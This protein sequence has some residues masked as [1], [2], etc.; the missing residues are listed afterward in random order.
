MHHTAPMAQQRCMLPRSCTTACLGT[1]SSCMCPPRQALP[2]LPLPCGLTVDCT[3]GQ[4]ATNAN[5]RSHYTSAH[6]PAATH[7]NVVPQPHDKGSQI[8]LLPDGMRQRQASQPGKFTAQHTQAIE[9][10]QLCSPALGPFSQLPCGKSASVLSGRGTIQALT[11]QTLL[12]QYTEPDKY[13][14]K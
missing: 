3:T 4:Q 11:Q 1:N 2:T 14:S 10:P 8:G 7:V 9:P 12:T 6:S 13:R 5:R